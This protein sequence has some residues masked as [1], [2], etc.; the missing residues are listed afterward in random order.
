MDAGPIAHQSKYSLKGNEMAEDVLQ[1]LFEIGTSRIIDMLPR[2]FDGKFTP[3]SCPQQDES[4]S[5]T[6][7]KIMAEES[8]VCFG[9][10]S[11]LNI[12]NKVRAFS[13]WPGVWVLMKVG[14]VVHKVKLIET[15]VV[16]ANPDMEVPPFETRGVNPPFVIFLNM[17]LI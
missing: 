5:T 7:P 17:F 8:Q 4:K 9:E 1:D 3:Q 2:V 11:A 10:R 15:R 14:D 16:E 12:H 6:A 13:T